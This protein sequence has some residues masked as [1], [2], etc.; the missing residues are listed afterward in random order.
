MNTEIAATS[1]KELYIKLTGY[2]REAVRNE[3]NDVIKTSRNCTIKHAKE[4]KRLKPS[5][6]EEV[7][8]RFQ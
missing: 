4:V 8:K 5:E 2:N 3:I 7:L 6:V 1:K